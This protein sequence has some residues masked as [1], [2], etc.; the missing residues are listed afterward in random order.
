MLQDPDL[1]SSPSLSDGEQSPLLGRTPAHHSRPMLAPDSLESS[2]YPALPG[3]AAPPQRRPAREVQPSGVAPPRALVARVMTGRRCPR[4]VSSIPWN[5][6][7]IKTTYGFTLVH[8]LQIQDHPDRVTVLPHRLP[9]RRE[10]TFS[11][12]HRQAGIHAADCPE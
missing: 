10:E 12:L 11:T 5:L 3:Q 4:H 1:R 9:G 8:R 7:L 6:L 2:A